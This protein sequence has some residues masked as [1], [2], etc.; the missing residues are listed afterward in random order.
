VTIVATT[1]GTGAAGLRVTLVERES[2]IAHM[3]GLS[4]RLSA[5]DLRPFHTRASAAW[6]VVPNYAHNL[7]S[8]SVDMG[9]PFSLAATTLGASMPGH[10]G[11]LRKLQA[12][13][14]TAVH[15]VEQASVVLPS[16]IYEFSI[17][18]MAAEE[19]VLVA[20]ND[21]SGSCTFNLATGVATN[22]GLPSATLSMELTPA[23][24]Y[25][26]RVRYTS[27]AGASSTMRWC[28]RLNSTYLGTGTDGLWCGQPQLQ[29]V[30]SGY[31]G[32]GYTAT[33]AAQAP[34][35]LTAY[36][37]NVLRVLPSPV[38]V[39]SAL[40]EPQSTNKAT[41][42][43]ANPTDLTGVSKIGD[44]A[45]TLTV[46]NDAAALAYAGLSGVCS[47]GNVYKLDN[48]LGA[49]AAYALASQAVGNTNPHSLSV[50]SRGDAG[51]L[52]VHVGTGPS[53]AL[54][55]AGSYVRSTAT[56]ACSNTTAVL[57]VGA[58]AGKVV[59]FILNQLEEQPFVTSPIVVAGSAVT[60]ARDEISIPV[61]ISAGQ[62][63]GLEVDFVKMGEAASTT[64]VTGGSAFGIECNTA[65]SV[66]VW[67]GATNL[68]AGTNGAVGT[69]GK[70]A[71][72]GDGSGRAVSLNGAAAATAANTHDAATGVV[73]GALSAGADSNAAPMYF[74]EVRTRRTRC[75]NNKLRRM[76]A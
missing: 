33:T 68:I 75:A 2:P 73:L 9:A 59:Y 49:T 23:G 16:R 34:Q 1:A 38:G 5:E 26:C 35:T 72:A 14:S 76:T 18:A 61:A 15:G 44:A 53:A 62:P 74:H 12:N 57:R 40:R 65:Q 54:P 47:T 41:N 58:A 70:V 7:F 25:I 36:A 56:G 17:E 19:T 55:A 10:R 11:T 42:Y 64:R 27:G 50:F 22:A 39:S 28:I 4:L 71:Y 69:R 46:V 29:D 66:R 43:N 21:S 6:A 51:T 8:Q 24:T 32:G 31:F 52:D 60:R 48:S 37:T 63:F 13:A 45:A 3:D 67:N 30:T 20:A